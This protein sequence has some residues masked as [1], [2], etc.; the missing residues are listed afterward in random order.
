MISTAVRDCQGKPTVGHR[1][2]RP[3]SLK[4]VRGRP[5]KFEGRPRKIEVSGPRSGLALAD[6]D[7]K[8]L[9]Q[10]DR[11]CS[12]ILASPRHVACSAYEPAGLRPWRRRSIHLGNGQQGGA[13]D[14]HRV[15]EVVQEPA[16]ESGLHADRAAHRDPDRRDPRRRR[17]PALPRLY[18]GRQDRRGQ[19]GGRLAVDAPSRA[20]PSEAAATP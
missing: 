16:V 14:G 18:Q 1:R 15:G 13:G 4:R 2:G 17:D 10:T 9:I 5:P 7:A 20:M 19:G 3:R 8:Y 12:T 11:T 6:I